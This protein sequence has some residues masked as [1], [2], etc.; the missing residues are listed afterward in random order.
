MCTVFPMTKD[1]VAPTIKFRNYKNIMKYPYVFYADT[2]SIIMPID[3]S[4]EQNN[5]VMYNMHIWCS[6]AYNIVSSDGKLMGTK[7]YRGKDAM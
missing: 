3:R 2:E 4:L 6:F 1:G 5:T 7:Y